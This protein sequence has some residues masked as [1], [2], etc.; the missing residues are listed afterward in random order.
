MKLHYRAQSSLQ[1]MPGRIADS[2]RTVD[3]IESMQQGDSRTVV[4]FGP[5]GLALQAQI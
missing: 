3:V 5:S 4:R 2:G 1:T